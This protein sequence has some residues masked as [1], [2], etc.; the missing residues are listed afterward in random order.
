MNKINI[1]KLADWLRDLIE[2][3]KDDESFCIAWYKE[4]ENDPFSI[5][6]GWM[7]G[8]SSDYDD[9]LCISKSDP[10]YAMCVKIAVNEGPYAY[11]DFEL[12][13][14]PIDPVTDEVDDT[15]IALDYD[16]DV[17][18][19]AQFLASEWERITEEYGDAEEDFA[20]C[21]ILG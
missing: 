2:A 13:D 15:C 1:D 12:M 5:I 7:E 4:T 8:F 10:E 18:G 21:I 9:V 20:N 19:L 16:E 14:M 17:V 6:G 3:A 11:T